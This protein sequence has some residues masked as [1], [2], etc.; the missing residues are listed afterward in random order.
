MWK[1]KK[2]AR[3]ILKLLFHFQQWF[4]ESFEQV[5]KK[6]FYCCNTL[7][8]CSANIWRP[9]SLTIL[10]SLHYTD[11]FIK[12]NKPV[13]LNVLLLSLQCFD[14]LLSIAIH[15]HT[16]K[17]PNSVGGPCGFHIKASLHVFCFCGLIW[18]KAWMV[19]REL[20]LHWIARDSIKTPLLWG[21]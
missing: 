6:L 8:T 20:S 13:F 15:S 3:V 1:L 18:H 5:K 21:N 9:Q 14:I 4:M 12:L 16:F 17:C 11:G 2:T 7:P 19:S 10:P